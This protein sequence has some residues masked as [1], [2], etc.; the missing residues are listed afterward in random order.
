MTEQNQ[1]LSSEEESRRVA[2]EAR[3]TEW[4]GRGFIRELFLGNFGLPLIHPFPERAPDTPEFAEFYGKLEK[5][6]KE[7]VDAVAIDQTGEYPE[8]V[9]KGLAEIGAYGIKI[10]KEYGGLGFS[11][12]EYCRPM[13]LLGSHDGNLVAL[14]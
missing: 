14:L 2:E 1:N 12:S 10:P 4:A 3:E 11:V 8:S 13:E 7:E 5:F 6:L 9:L